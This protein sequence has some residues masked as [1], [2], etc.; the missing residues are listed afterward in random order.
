MMTGFARRDV[1]MAGIMGAVASPLV[2]RTDIPPSLDVL[3]RRK[4][5]RFG[6]AISWATAGADRGSI[7]NPPYARLVAAECGVIVAEMR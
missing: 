6:S 1:L 2:A 7:A 4:G 3:A 5:L